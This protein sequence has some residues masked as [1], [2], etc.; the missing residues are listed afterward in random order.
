MQKIKAM[1]D[2]KDHVFRLSLLHM[3]MLILEEWLSLAPLTIPVVILVKFH[4]FR[5]IN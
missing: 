5:Q 1:M 2:L 3:K 4:S